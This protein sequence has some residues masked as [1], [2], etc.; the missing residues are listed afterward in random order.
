MTSKRVF[1][2]DTNEKPL[3]SNNSPTARK[4][5]RY[6]KNTVAYD[7][8]TVLEDSKV[9]IRPRYPADDMRAAKRYKSTSRRKNP[10]PQ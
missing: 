3:N 9:S 4:A 10:Y 1:P 2:I 7:K 8:I 5:L 6:R